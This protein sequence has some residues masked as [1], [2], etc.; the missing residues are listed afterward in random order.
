MKN[1]KY[2]IVCIIPARGGSKGIPKKNLIPF[3]GESLLDWSILL[4]EK[5]I[6]SMRF[7]CPQ[8]PYIYC[9]W[10]KYMGRIINILFYRERQ[11][12]VSMP[13]D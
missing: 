2:R 3:C 4:A 8:T 11:M 13:L 12:V 7:M 9:E 1:P 10:G 6:K 5:V